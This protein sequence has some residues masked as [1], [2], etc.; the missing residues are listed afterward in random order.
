M[1]TFLKWLAT[2]PLG[3]ALKVGL[4]ATFGWVLENIETLNVPSVLSVAL[5]TAIPV[6]INWLNPQDKR[7]GAGK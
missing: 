7:Y 4:A 2:S 5:V 6:I 1:E 3:S